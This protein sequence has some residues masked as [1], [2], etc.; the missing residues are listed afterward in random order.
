MISQL[1]H[2]PQG[3]NENMGFVT[4]GTLDEC[5][6][7]MMWLWQTIKY[8]MTTNLTMYPNRTFMYKGTLLN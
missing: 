3:V 8:D 6:H 2:H 7:H 4:D 1:A 5:S